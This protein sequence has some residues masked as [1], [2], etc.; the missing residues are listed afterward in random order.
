V[1]L[2]ATFLTFAPP[3]IHALKDPKT[4]NKLKSAFKQKFNN[5]SD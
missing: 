5:K 2:L 1:V 3:L 4:R